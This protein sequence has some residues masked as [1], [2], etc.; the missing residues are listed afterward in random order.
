[1]SENGPESG[2]V[3]DAMSTLAGDHLGP[4]SGALTLFIV[5]NVQ[6]ALQSPRPTLKI[7]S[8]VMLG[9]A[10]TYGMRWAIHAGIGYLRVATKAQ[11][12]LAA[13]TLVDFAFLV[14]LAFVAARAVELPHLDRVLWLAG[15]LLIGVSLSA[16]L[17]QLVRN[18]NGELREYQPTGTQ[19]VARRRAVRYLAQLLDTLGNIPPLSAPRHLLKV[20]HGR[21]V[22]VYVATVAMIAFSISTGIA[23]GYLLH[24][25]KT[26]EKTALLNHIYSPQT[27]TAPHGGLDPAQKPTPPPRSSGELADVCST[28]AAPG[29]VAPKQRRA[30]AAVQAGMKR[31]FESPAGASGIGRGCPWVTHRE[32]NH[33]TLWWE[34]GW[35]GQN[36]RSLVVS[37]GTTTSVVYGEAAGLARYAAVHGL[38]AGT[39]GLLKIGT[40]DL[41]LI[42]TTYGTVAATRE[43]VPPSAVRH[44]SGVMPCAGTAAAL[45]STVQLPPAL[46]ALWA[47]LTEQRRQW[48]WPVADESRGGRSYDFVS[49]APGGPI[50]ARGTCTRTGT[51]T[52]FDRSSRR[53][54]RFTHGLTVSAAAVERLAPA[55]QGAQPRR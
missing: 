41:Q 6:G 8:R 13:V 12:R 28:F 26:S 38:L 22:S 46:S 10:V 51:C 48:L 1:M 47:W 7:D 5:F 23:F 30:P 50:V 3:I 36:L 37:D 40:G 31:M 15:L 11:R 19:W 2:P 55:G 52:V 17:T 39:S 54:Q 32:K 42:G 27:T 43:L 20:D 35:C 29:S 21:L 25:P 9:L 45:V 34:T 44:G 24:A 49:G 18:G 14:A 33:P 16:G 53:T 4:I